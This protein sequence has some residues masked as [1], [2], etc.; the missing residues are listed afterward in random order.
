VETEQVLTEVNT[1][2]AGILDG[3]TK[4]A[5]RDAA[6]EAKQAELL[7]KITEHD[8]GLK[9][10]K[11]ELERIE[12]ELNTK[13]FGA[14]SGSVTETDALLNALPDDLKAM[15]SRV[16]GLRFAPV[17]PGLSRS[18]V[19][20]RMAESDP[21]R[22]V[23]IGGWF[24]ARV[25]Q[26]LFAKKGQATKAQEWDERA[27]KLAEAM[28]GFTAEQKAALQEDTNAEGGFLIPTVTEAMIGWLMKEASIVRSAGATILSMTTK[29]HQLPTLA[30]D[31]SVSWIAE[32]GTI[33]DGAPATPFGQGS[34]T[35]KKLASL[36]TVSIEL[37]Q[38]NI[39]NLMDFV[40]R[41]LLQQ[42]GRAEDLQAL[43]GDG[44]VFSGL[45]SVSGVNSVAGGS[46]ALSEDELR[47][48]IYGG[49]H[50][51]T[52]ENGVIFA[53]P[54]IMRDAIGLAISSGTPWFATVFGQDQ[55]GNAR[56]RNIWGVPAYLSSIVAKNR[57][58]GTNETTAYHG[59]PSYIVIGDRMG[60]TFEV[61]PYGKFDTAQLR[62]R[63]LRRVGVLIWVPAYFTKLTAVTVS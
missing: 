15:V 26:A 50:A 18:A 57:G 3:Q 60:T 12:R 13:R 25:K 51:T 4:A 28:G 29:T 1:K 6:I 56:P 20:V 41:H 8:T 31:F 55:Q 35:A 2:L 16:K 54:W 22:Y 11:K 27:N 47:R 53:H 45:F 49:E 38:D 43:E 17:A 23:A 9:D 63:L 24:Q 14:G 52:L 44:T 46:N 7:G 39:V 21:V 34:L 33:T 5:A 37:V 30:N 19:A 62:L 40:L 42:A 59:D 58:G 61:D 36:V 10:Q 32:E 48:L